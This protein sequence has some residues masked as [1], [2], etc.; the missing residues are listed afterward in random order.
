MLEFKE[1]I[2]PEGLDSPLRHYNLYIINDL[3]MNWH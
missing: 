2:K 3:E 1:V